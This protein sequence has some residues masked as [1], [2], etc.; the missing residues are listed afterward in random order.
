MEYYMIIAR[1]VTYA[2]RIERELRRAG[3]RAVLFRAPLELTGG[4]G[5]SYA[6][7]V[8]AEAGSSAMRI[9]RTSGLD[10]V[11]ILKIDGNRATEVLYDLL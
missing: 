9:L 8:S 7:R 1:S 4:A 3:I 5:C 11:R 6:V 10:A 2:Q